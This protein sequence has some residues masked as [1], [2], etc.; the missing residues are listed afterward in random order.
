MDL[1]EPNG[2]ES[3]FRRP[4]VVIQS[5]PLNGSRLRTTIVAAMNSNL[6]RDR[7]TEKVSPL[8]AKLLRALDT[9]LRLAFEVWVSRR[10]IVARTLPLRRDQSPHGSL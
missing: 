3:G 4:V 7:L 2:S 1:E 9:G 8:P 10:T 6:A 5:D